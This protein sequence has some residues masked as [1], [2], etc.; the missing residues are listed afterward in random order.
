MT[1]CDKHLVELGS[2]GWQDGNWIRILKLKM[3]FCNLI[4]EKHR[5]I[6]S[7]SSVKSASPLLLCLSRYSKTGPFRAQPAVFKNTCHYGMQTSSNSTISGTTLDFVRKKLL[8]SI[9]IGT[10]GDYRS[11][12]IVLQVLPWKRVS[13]IVLRAPLA[14]SSMPVEEFGG[15]FNDSFFSPASTTTDFLGRKWSWK[16]QRPLAAMDWWNSHICQTV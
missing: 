12:L 16:Q 15:D 6:L 2:M 1:S 14:R 3:S 7:M 8:A 13:D 4:Y 10:I 5:W 9:R 11:L